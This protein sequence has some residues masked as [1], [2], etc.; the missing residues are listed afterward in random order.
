MEA[1]YTVDGA[2]D[3]KKTQAMIRI[4]KGAISI[5][6]SR[7]GDVVYRYNRHEKKALSQRLC[8]YDRESARSQVNIDSQK[9]D[10]LR[11][12]KLVFGRQR[13]ISDSLRSFDEMLE[14][15]IA[16]CRIFRSRG[17]EVEVK[18]S[19]NE[20]S[21]KEE[22]ETQEEVEQK[23][24]EAVILQLDLKSNT[25]NSALP[26]MP[27]VLPRLYLGGA[28]NNARLEDKERESARRE[29]EMEE[30]RLQKRQANE[31]P[32]F[33]WKMMK[34]FLN[35]QKYLH[36]DL[37]TRNALLKIKTDVGKDHVFFK[38][39]VKTRLPDN[40][41]TLLERIER[42]NTLPVINYSTH[43]SARPEAANRDSRHRGS[44]NHNSRL[45]GSEST[46]TNVVRRR[47]VGKVEENG[48]TPRSFVTPSP[49]GQDEASLKVACEKNV[50][51]STERT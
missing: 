1:L 38:Y 13:S 30:K 15:A 7:T 21:K 31:L 26:V 23:P 20:E 33:D 25:N 8:K 44:A 39:L 35:D 50:R 29:R 16:T 41:H 45:V 24:E 4:L 42:G 22:G 17:D 51:F 27:I 40:A 9:R 34:C 46:K 18:N 11:K 14:E 43:A 32:R 19:R 49:R 6:K 47:K 10:V 12:W 28:L 36:Q 5:S 37:L 3:K 2:T 48:F